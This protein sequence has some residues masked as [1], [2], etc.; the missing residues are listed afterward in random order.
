LIRLAVLVNRG[1]HEFPV[2]ADYTGISLQVPNERKVAVEFVES[3][4]QD[5]VC[6][7]DWKKKTK[8][9]G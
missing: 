4:G 5:R 8:P 9:G 6:T 2:G 7:I 1:N 3:D